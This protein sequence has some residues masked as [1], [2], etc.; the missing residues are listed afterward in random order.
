[1]T[2]VDASIMDSE[3]VQMLSIINEE[4]DC[5]IVINS[6]GIIQFANKG[7]TTVSPHEPATVGIASCVRNSSSASNALDFG[8]CHGDVVPGWLE[9]AIKQPY[10]WSHLML[11]DDLT[12][13]TV[14]QV[15]GWDKHDVEGKSVSMLMPPPFSQMHNIFLRNYAETGVGNIINTTREVQGLHQDRYSFP[16]KIAVTKVPQSGDT[17]SAVVLL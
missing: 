13:I 10:A 3:T 9:N 2:R 8:G 11:A 14:C 17:T 16:I 4:K 5:N 12:L 15:F 7:L 1:M 6:E